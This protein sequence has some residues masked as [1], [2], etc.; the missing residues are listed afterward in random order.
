MQVI[1]FRMKNELKLTHWN[2]EVIGYC[3]TERFDGFWSKHCQLAACT[4]VS[5]KSIDLSLYP[6]E[7][8][9]FAN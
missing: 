4:I 5:T 9:Y 8:T 3:W 2:Y 7:H 1:Y 6:H